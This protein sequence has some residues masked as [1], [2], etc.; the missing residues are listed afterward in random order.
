MSLDSSKYYTAIAIQKNTKNYPTEYEGNTVVN[1]PVD[2]C[3]CTFYKNS[4]GNNVSSYPSTYCNSGECLYST[5]EGCNIGGSDSCYYNGTLLDWQINSDTIGCSGSTQKTPS[6]S[7]VDYSLCV[8]EPTNNQPLSIDAMN[9]LSQICSNIPLNQPC[10]T[11]NYV[12]PQGQV[13]VGWRSSGDQVISKSSGRQITCSYN[14]DHFSNNP[15]NLV[16]QLTAFNNN[17]VSQTFNGISQTNDT[18]TSNTQVYNQMMQDYSSNIASPGSDFTCKTY[19][20]FPYQGVTPTNCNRL[21][22][23]GTQGDYARGWSTGSQTNNAV[24]TAYLD[25]AKLTYCNNNINAPECQ[26]INRSLVDSNYDNLQSII[27]LPPACWYIPCQDGTNYL[28]TSDIYN[29]QC[30]PT[31]CE[32]INANFANSGSTITPDEQNTVS[33]TISSDTQKNN[34][35]TVTNNFISFI[36]NHVW[37]FLLLGLGG[38]IIIGIIIFLIVKNKK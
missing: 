34:T 12:G 10:N 36:T 14:K 37:L 3:Y 15:T 38:I 7:T 35:G 26:C 17:F 22:S 23:I 2:T 21:V 32:N 29:V 19:E 30:S 9:T 1:E 4:Q 8:L 18:I 20:I 5:L 27:G 28:I 13:Y 16:P 11:T 6:C 33:C 25:N 31:I 24:P